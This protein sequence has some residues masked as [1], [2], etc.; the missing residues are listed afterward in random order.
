MKGKMSGKEMKPKN[1]GTGKE[2]VPPGSKH[3][4]KMKKEMRKGKKG[5]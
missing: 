2:S 3:P 4:E 1:K 5:C